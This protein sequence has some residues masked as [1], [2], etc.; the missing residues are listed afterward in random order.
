[1]NIAL[2]RIDSR[3][4]TVRRGRAL[5]LRSVWR[6]A[7]IGSA[8]DAVCGGRPVALRA[9]I[10]RVGFVTAPRWIRPIRA[11]YAAKRLPTAPHP[12]HPLWT[13]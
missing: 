10:F 11:G 12:I 7:V 5:A 3:A 8:A 1:M 6:R 13:G 2:H 4:D 9:R